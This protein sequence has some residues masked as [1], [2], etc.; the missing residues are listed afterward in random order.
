[1]ERRAMRNSPCFKLLYSFFIRLRKSIKEMEFDLFIDDDWLLFFI[2]CVLHKNITDNL[3]ITFT[4]LVDSILPGVINLWFHFVQSNNSTTFPC[5]YI[6]CQTLY[7]FSLFHLLFNI[8]TTYDL[9]EWCCWLFFCSIFSFL[10]L[11]LNII[12]LKYRLRTCLTQHNQ[13]ID[14]KFR[15]KWIYTQYES[16]LF[17]CCVQRK[18]NKK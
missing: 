18:K 7:F 8:I 17:L 6:I 3:Y 12:Y 15:L 14:Y 4:R 11:I 13:D 10:M 16:K 2:L 1:M 5:T 9:L